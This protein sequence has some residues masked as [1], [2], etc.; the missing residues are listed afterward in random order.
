LKSFELSMGMSVSAT[1]LEIPTAAATATPNSRNSRPTL[2]W[3]KEMGRNTETSTRVVAMT[4]KPISRLPFTAASS[5][6]SPS[7]TRRQMFSSTTMASST[8][9][10]IASTRPSRIST[11]ME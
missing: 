8:T 6:G 11:L 10:P 1:R 2:P 9:R 3:M 4:A 5:G 7:S